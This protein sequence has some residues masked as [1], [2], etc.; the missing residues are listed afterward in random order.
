M[1]DGSLDG[2]N[3]EIEDSVKL[4]MLDGMLDGSLDMINEGIEDGFKLGEV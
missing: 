3:E 4:S 1:L 2:I